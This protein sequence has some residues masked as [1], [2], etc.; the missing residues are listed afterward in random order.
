MLIDDADAQ[1]LRPGGWLVERLAA[2]FDRA[3]V[4]GHGAGGDRHQC[5]LSGA[6]LADQRMYLALDDLQAYAVKSD[7]AW[8]GLDDVGEA[9]NGSGL[10]GTFSGRVSSLRLAVFRELLG[11]SLTN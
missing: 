11:L 1:R 8:K 10:C 3:G 2:D 7:N 6:V 4:P 5:R 9:Q